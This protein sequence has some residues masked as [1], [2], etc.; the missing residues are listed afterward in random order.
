MGGAHERAPRQDVGTWR[1]CGGPRSAG[2]EK[3]TENP[4]GE[5]SSG[6]CCTTA[7]T[8][9][10][11]STTTNVAASVAAPGRIPANGVSI[12]PSTSVSQWRAWCAIRLFRRHTK[13]GEIRCAELYRVGMLCD[14]GIEREKFHRGQF[15]V[16]QQCGRKGQ[17]GQFNGHGQ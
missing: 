9:T 2:T 7:Y 16:V 1:C 15:H 12:R 13:P 3:Y 6:H 11:M 8:R 17:C 10:G 14:E 4:R 5:C